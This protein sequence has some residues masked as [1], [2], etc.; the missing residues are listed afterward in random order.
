MLYDWTKLECNN[1][2]YRYVLRALEGIR[3]RPELI[4]LLQ[5]HDQISSVRAI[6]V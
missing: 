6:G 5:L 2:L 4:N 1:L 3:T